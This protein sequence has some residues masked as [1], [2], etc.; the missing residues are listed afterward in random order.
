VDALSM[1]FLQAQAVIA[2]PAAQPQKRTVDPMPE[3]W[4]EDNGPPPEPKAKRGARWT[5]PT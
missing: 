2:S 4:D 1:A 3:L 5:R